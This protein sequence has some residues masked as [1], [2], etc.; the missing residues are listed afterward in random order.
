MSLVGP[1]ALAVQSA[2]ALVISHGICCGIIMYH[3]LNGKWAKYTLHKTRCVSVQDYIDGAKSLF[4]DLFLLFLPFMTV[5]YYFRE[6]AI[7]ESEDT[8][9]LALTKLGIGYLVGKLWAFGVHYILHFPAFYKYHRQ[10]HCNPKTLVAS[11]AW[12]DSFVEYAIMEL[13]SFAMVIVLF[14]TR[15]WAHLLHFIWHGWDGA[16]GHSGFCAPGWLGAAFD[17]TY[18]YHHHAHLTVNY[19]EVEIL[20]KLFGTH[21][22]QQ[23]AKKLHH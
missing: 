11:R 20:D 17:G 1:F 9:M 23:A 8:I 21:H 13:P 4:A 18:H 2:T 7:R 16:A 6:S 14:P 15:F 12:Q 3:D 10:H 5:C 19:A 22:T